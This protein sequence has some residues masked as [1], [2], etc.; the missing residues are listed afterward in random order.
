M[1]S[2]EA[3]AIFHQQREAF[4]GFFPAVSSARLTIVRRACPGPSTGCA[5]RDLAWMV[6]GDVYLLARALAR[7]RNVVAA[8]IAHELGH[9][10]D[11]ARWLPGSEQ[12]AD[13]FA[14]AVLSKRVRYTRRDGVQTFGPGLWPRPLYLHQ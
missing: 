14:A 10:V 5:G 6:G 4:A 9:A 11:I 13:D 1:T 3:R 12:R 2:A 8:L 7:S